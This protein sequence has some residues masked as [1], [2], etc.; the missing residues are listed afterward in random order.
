MRFP[1]NFLLIDNGS[2]AGKF[3]I[4]QLDLVT[5]GNC[6]KPALILK[7]I[8]QIPNFRMYPLDRPQIE[9]RL[10]CRT[11]NFAGLFAL[12]IQDFF[13]ILFL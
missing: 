6:P 9:Q 11:L 3:L 7:Q 1:S 13:A 8:R 4:Y 2:Y 12:A 10:L 5:P